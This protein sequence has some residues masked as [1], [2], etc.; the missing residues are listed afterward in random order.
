MI[1]KNLIVD[2]YKVLKNVFYIKD[3]IKPSNVSD[4]AWREKY[5]EFSTVSQTVPKFAKTVINMLTGERIKQ[6]ELCLK[7]FDEDEHWFFINGIM[8]TKEVA[9]INQMALENIFG[10]EF[11]TLYNPTN[12][13]LADILESIYERTFDSYADITLHLFDAVDDMIYKDKKVKIIAHSQGGIILSNFLKLIKEHSQNGKDYSNLEIYTFAS[14]ADEEVSIEGVHQEHFGNEKDFVAR[15][16]LMFENTQGK[17]YT[18]NNGV[19]HLLNQDYLEHFKSGK[20]CNGKSKLF[21][22]TQ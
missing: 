9:A 18:L 16:G 19:G 13:F 2:T 3:V 21:S 10:K 7:D 11:H 17:F 22:Y 20:Y 5:S 1:I 12:G 4:P 14:A 6:F 15:L 8:T